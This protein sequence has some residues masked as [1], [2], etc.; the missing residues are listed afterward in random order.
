MNTIS[1]NI[2]NR[3]IIFYQLNDAG[4]VVYVADYQK[5]CDHIDYWKAFLLDRYSAKSGQLLFIDCSFL[6]IYYYSLIF[7][8]AELGL[9]IVL[10]MPHAY[11]EEDLD[12]VKMNMHGKIDFV[13]TN[14][15][16]NNQDIFW[17]WQR[18]LKLAVNLI[19]P[20]D[21]DQY[22]LK[23]PT[24]Y[25]LAQQT[26]VT[27]P[28]TLFLRYPSSGSTGTPQLVVNSHRKVYAMSER[29]IPQ[30]EYAAGDSAVHIM[31]MFH[32]AA[33]CYHFLP[34][35]MTVKTHYMFSVFDT[36][37]AFNPEA[38][39][40][41]IEKLVEVV[42][43]HNI[44][45]VKIPTTS[46]LEKFIGLL[47]RAPSPMKICTLFQISPAMVA[48]LKDKN[49]RSIKT[50]F[51]DTTIAM[52]LFIKT[53]YQDQDLETYDV[54]EMG[55]PYDDFFDFD[56]RDQRL[57]IRIPS[58]QQDWKTSNDLFEFRD[59]KYYFKGRANT[60]RING[61]WVGHQQLETACTKCFGAMNANV[62]FDEDRQKIY[63]A[64]WKKNDAAVQA[65]QTYLTRHFKNIKVD[66]V[67]EHEEYH[68]FFNS[69]KIDAEK[70][71]QI[72][73][74]RLNI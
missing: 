60:Y 46:L 11:C 61:E 28:D 13:Y 38:G 23:D 33:L 55:R 48:Q 2:I 53:V 21:Y 63:L 19:Q 41:N 65:F 32:G 34:S 14:R 54:T 71:R 59:G 7:A 35:I 30:M 67:L 10:D 64:L 20:C 17:D 8:A 16:P 66:Y 27:D 1:R 5:L 25:S 50:L 24:N 69:R 58:L 72:C 56:I 39:I 43:R 22:Q 3:D 31:N 40:S 6:D 26:F 44:N 45:A 49:I 37:N 57:W 15:D 9:I 52:G 29:L 70:I 73:R 18:N 68:A 42:K 47:D 62:V 51:G 36:K 12:N 4:D 74:E